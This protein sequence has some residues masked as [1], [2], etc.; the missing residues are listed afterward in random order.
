VAQSLRPFPQFTNA[1]TPLWAPLG[2]NWYNSLQLQ[3]IQRFSHGLDVNYNFTWSKSLDNGIEGQMNDIYNRDTNKFL[4]G[5]DR[6]LVSNINISYTVPVAPWTGNKILKSVL[7]DWQM[8]ALLTYASGTPILV[9]ASTNQLSSQT[10]LTTSYLNRDPTAPLFLQ[11]LNCHC[12]DPTK[13]LVLNPAAWV[14]PPA[15]TYGTSPA[16]YN[17]YRSQRHPT[18][19]FNV[20]RTF[21]IREAMSLSV[22]AEFANIFNRTVLPAPSS[23]TPLTAPTC[24]L[25]GVSGPTGACSSGAAYASGFGVESTL[26]I[27]GGTR[28]GQIVARLRF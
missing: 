2:D 1:P 15:G 19:N 24:F 26:G 20:G 9:P 21:R 13:T 14:S 28:T 17:D 4:S 18:E 5:S 7:S 3:V 23:T 16:Y 27:T 11:D 12:F 22:R 25:S 8:G 6:P 10:F